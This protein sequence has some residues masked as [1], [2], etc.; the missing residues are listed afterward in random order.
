[1]TAGGCS[2]STEDVDGGVDKNVQSDAGVSNCELGLIGWKTRDAFWKM[3]FSQMLA[4]INSK[5][6]ATSATQSVWSL[7]IWV[8]ALSLRV[9]LPRRTAPSN[10][11]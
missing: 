10:R 1:M 3:Y 6:T 5:R 9:S 8:V 7:G 11:L 4:T 2:T